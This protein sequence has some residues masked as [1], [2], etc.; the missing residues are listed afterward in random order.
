MTDL[1]TIDDVQEI[2]GE[3]F[4]EPEST[5]VARY[6]AIASAKLRTRVAGID[7]RIAAGTLDPVLV[8]GVGAEIVMRA[9]ATV[10]R[11]LGVRRTEY[12]EISTEY[13]PRSES[14]LVFVT[15]DDIADLID[16]A[17]SGD[18]FTIRIDA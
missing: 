11:G 5:Q 12:P 3:T 2:S 17:D 7:D 15:D 6:I 13:E 1:F 8:V 10:R 16:T 14:G 4:V 9:V 18:S